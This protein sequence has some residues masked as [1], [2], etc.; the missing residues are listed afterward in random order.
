M[1]PVVL[2]VLTAM[3][4]TA[5][6]PE[7]AS[8]DSE[9]VTTEYQGEPRIEHR[10]FAFTVDPSTPA[11]GTVSLG[12]TVG[13]GSGVSA[14]RPIP[15]V[16]QSAGL[17]NQLSLGYGVTN[18]LAPVAEL[19]VVSSNGSST[20]SGTLGMKLQLTSP[21]APWRAALMAGTLREGTSGAYGTWLRAAGSW[22][23]GRLLVEMNAYA[24]SVFATGRDALDYAIMAGTSWHLLDWLRAGAEYVGQDL[25]EMGTSG[26]EGGAR[27]AVGPSVAV[28]LDR[29]R[30]QLV[31]ATLFGLGAQSP[32]AIVRV[33]LLGTY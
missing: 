22:E 8:P 18:W 7:H 13:M 30:Y 3:G 29:G 20:A 31:A 12:Y 19:T 25:E 10:P 21:D 5:T 23:S 27:Q 4:G 15:I 2:I 32:A 9:S 17:S 16:L 26:A 28:S 1:T 24:E 14:D 33:G 6:S 11:R